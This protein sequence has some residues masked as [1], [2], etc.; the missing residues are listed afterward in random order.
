MCV[1]SRW[2]LLYYLSQLVNNSFLCYLFMEDKC[3]LFLFLNTWNFCVR[4]QLSIQI[5]PLSAK[6]LLMD[7]KISIS[8]IYSQSRA[9]MNC[10]NFIW[11]KTHW[12]RRLNF[13]FNVVFPLTEIWIP[14]L[15]YRREACWPMHNPFDVYSNFIKGI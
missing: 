9:R 5:F 7:Y 10:S 1:K 8:S 13:Y 3:F 15:L 4:L 11:L 14:N 6:K 12:F 2:E